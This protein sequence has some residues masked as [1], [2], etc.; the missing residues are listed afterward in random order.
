M[1]ST[2]TPPATPIDEASDTLLARMRAAAD[3]LELVS[4]DHSVLDALPREDRERLQRAVAGAYHPDRQARRQRQKA[5]KKEQHAARVSREE[6]RLNQTG[7]REL[8]RKPVF[9]T[10]NYFPPSDFQPRDLDADQP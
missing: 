9:T 7:I 6:E 8:R 1:M 4:T 5:A 10:P 3:L 2:A